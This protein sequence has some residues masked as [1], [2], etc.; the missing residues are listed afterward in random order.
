M[1]AHVTVPWEGEKIKNGKPCKYHITDMKV[2]E[3][4]QVAGTGADFSRGIYNL[5]GT[6]NEHGIFQYKKNYQN[7]AY[8]NNS[9]AIYQGQ[10]ANGQ[11][12]GMYGAMGKSDNFHI[13]MKDAVEFAI[14][15]SRPDVPQ[16]LVTRAHIVVAKKAIFGLGRDN[17]GFFVVSG[18]K[19]KD[20][21]AKRGGY[22]KF[23]IGVVYGGKFKIQLDGQMK[24]DHHIKTF[25][26]TWKNSSINMAGVFEFNQVT[27]QASGLN[28]GLGHPGQIAQDN[29]LAQC[30][31]GTRV[32][33][34][35]E[36][37]AANPGFPGGFGQQTSMGQPNPVN[38]GQQ[39]N[40]MN[41]QPQPFAQPHGVGFG[42]QSNPQ[43][44]QN[45]YQQQSFGFP[46]N[47]GFGQPTN[48]AFNQPQP[49][50][51]AQP[52]NPSFGQQP[53]PSFGQQPNPSFAQPYNLG[54]QTNPN[55]GQQAKAPAPYNGGYR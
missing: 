13:K 49:N 12:Q 24:E 27:Q 15:Y 51:F 8:N 17:N 6:V 7:V 9:V 16:M 34:Y 3:M 48:P 21:N 39:V 20:A 2:D 18:Q 28:A 54:Q 22:T 10:Y 38:F 14:S 31:F 30:L 19:V 44:G 29:I 4:G 33:N 41:N 47:G 36:Y 53:N 5:Q 37:Q 52:T 42:Q 11:I 50:P 45:P 43:F 26:G 1:G 35:A 25:K 46:Q 23:N 40:P 55:F 32:F